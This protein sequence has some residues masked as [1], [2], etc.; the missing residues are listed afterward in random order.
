MTKHSRTKLVAPKTEPESQV[1]ETIEESSVPEQIEELA[2]T[3][4]DTETECPR[5]HEIMELQS[6][7]DALAYCCENCCF[8]LKCV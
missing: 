2:L 1:L 8:V 7:F 5:C 4:L 3:E 6:S